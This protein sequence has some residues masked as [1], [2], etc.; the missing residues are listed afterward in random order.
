MEKKEEIRHQLHLLKLIGFL[1]PLF[2]GMKKRMKV[3]DLTKLL[4]HLTG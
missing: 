2:V 1:V 4:P 3:P